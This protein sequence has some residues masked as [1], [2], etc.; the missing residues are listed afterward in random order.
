[1]N[2]SVIPSRRSVLAAA[3]TLLLALS[4]AERSHPDVGLATEPHCIDG[5]AHGVVHLGTGRR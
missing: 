4:A 5:V 3:G 2:A 1:M